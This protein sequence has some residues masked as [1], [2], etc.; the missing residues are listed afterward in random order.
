MERLRKRAEFAAVARGRRIEKPGFVLQAARREGKAASGAGS[1]LSGAGA[2]FGFTVTK[3]LG[4]AP[5]RNRIR[6]R[7]REAVKIAAPAHAAPGM[8]YV[9]V[10]RGTA[11]RQPFDRLVA[12][13]MD[14]LDRVSVESRG[15]GRRAGRAEP[16]RA[17]ER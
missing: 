8:N 9:L 12:D 17:N 15:S 3:R 5:T 14:G 2:R 7:L 11:L 6:R 4:N 1:P 16:E 13:L 10:G